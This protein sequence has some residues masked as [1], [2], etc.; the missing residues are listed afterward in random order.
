MTQCLVRESLCDCY[1]MHSILGTY[2]IHEQQFVCAANKKV[3]F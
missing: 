1:Y 3:D 2:R